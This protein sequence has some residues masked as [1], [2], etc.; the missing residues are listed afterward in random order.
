MKETNSSLQVQAPA[1]PMP[2][3]APLVFPLL[4]G[5]GWSQLGRKTLQQ[6]WYFFF[7]SLGKVKV[8][9]TPTGIFWGVQGLGELSRVMSYVF[10]SVLCLLF[11]GTVVVTTRSLLRD[12]RFL[13]HGR[14]SLALWVLWPQ[15][16]CKMSIVYSLKGDIQIPD[17]GE[18]ISLPDQG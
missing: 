13:C 1:V 6:H 11:P 8:C 18:G 4:P 15:I 3:M 12:W 7:H 2:S 16:H 17:C 5:Q 10:F 14:M 9:L